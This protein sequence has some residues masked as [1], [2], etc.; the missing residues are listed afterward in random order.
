MD[1]A[2]VQEHAG[3]V[4]CLERDKNGARTQFRYTLHL[5]PDLV[6][7]PDLATRKK[8]G[9]ELVL[10]DIL[11]NNI[12]QLESTQNYTEALKGLTR[13]FRGELRHLVGKGGGQTDENVA[14]NATES[15]AES[16]TGHVDTVVLNKLW[17]AS[18]LMMEKI[19]ATEQ[20]RRDEHWKQ[21]VHETQEKCKKC[22]GVSN[23]I[24]ARWHKA[25]AM[26]NEN[27]AKL[28]AKL[29]GI[30]KEKVPL[31]VLIA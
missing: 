28:T 5:S 20:T 17:M 7:Q 24:M 26:Y 16:G 10:D 6:S 8:T 14:M 2:P 30:E 3:A 21:M 29:A 15:G 12:S 4:G 18:I 11:C 27:M 22:E 31:L 19:I 13:L 1:R 25:E 23:D 9:S